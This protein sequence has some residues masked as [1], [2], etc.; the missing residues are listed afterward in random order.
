MTLVVDRCSKGYNAFVGNGV[1]MGKAACR[2]VGR[3]ALP[4]ATLVSSCQPCEMCLAAMRWAGISR[5]VFGAEQDK[6]D[7][8]MFRFPALTLSDFHAASAGD[9]EY[10]GGVEA[11]RVLHLYRLRD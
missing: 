2:T 11:E 9:F 1:N 5:V 3:P 6:I 8:E 7:A 10:V 4:G